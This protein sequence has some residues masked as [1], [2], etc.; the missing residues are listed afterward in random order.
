M[1]HRMIHL[2]R[3]ATLGAAVSLSACGST[4]PPAT[5]SPSTTTGAARSLSSNWRT[6]LRQILEISRSSERTPA[7]RV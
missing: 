6:A 7:S 2:A 4:E 3:I 5:P 1:K